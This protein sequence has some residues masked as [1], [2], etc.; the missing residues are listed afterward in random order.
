[1]AKQRKSNSK[2]TNAIRQRNKKRMLEK[3]LKKMTK[4]ES[5]ANVIRDCRIGRKAEG[6][7]QEAFKHKPPKNP[8]EDKETLVRLAISYEPFWNIDNGKTLCK[9]CHNKTKL[10]KFTCQK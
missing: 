1:M 3:K 7:Q 6:F 4:E 8:I 9:I 10:G 2:Y 5:I